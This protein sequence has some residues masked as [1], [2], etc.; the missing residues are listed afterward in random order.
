MYYGRTNSTVGGG[1]TSPIQ[2]QSKEV[3]ATSF[4]TQ[5]VPDEGYYLTSAKVN[6]PDNLAAG[7]IKKDVTIAG[8]TGT[9]EGSAST[10][11]TADIKPTAF[12][13]VKNA[14]DDGVD[15]YSTVTVQA[16]DNLVAENI[17]SGVSIAGVTG[18]YEG[19]GGGS[20]QLDDR[21]K[22]WMRAIQNNGKRYDA[23]GH[24]LPFVMLKEYWPDKLQAYEISTSHGTKSDLVMTPYC[25]ARLDIDSVELPEGRGN[26]NGITVLPDYA[27]YYLYSGRTGYVTVTGG[28]SEVYSFGTQAFSH[29]Y[30]TDIPNINYH[31]NMLGSYIFNAT[32]FETC[33]VP[34]GIT[35]IENNALQYLKVKDHKIILPTT[36]TKISGYAAIGGSSDNHATLVLKSTSPPSLVNSNSIDKN[37]VD[38]IVVP[39]GTLEAYRTATN[40]SAFADKM[41]EATADA[42]TTEAGA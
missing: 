41:V 20:G 36:L 2:T 38:Q 25:C 17:K 16:P 5:V 22:F 42:G 14:S 19:S 34:E 8:V 10:L 4:P 26:D 35:R 21:T 6:A 37:Y 9:F 30:L 32:V 15:G 40:W 27:F 29:A 13:T 28:A 24:L 1:S 18:T 12:P 11:G 33:N 3:K 39:A 7:N 23:E 31:Q